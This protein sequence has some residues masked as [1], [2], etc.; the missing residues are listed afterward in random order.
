M[1]KDSY[2]FEKNCIVPCV[3]GSYGWVVLRI[4][5]ALTIFRSY[6]NLKAGDAQSLKSNW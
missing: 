5:V 1:I 3:L 4:Y 2:G 6:Y